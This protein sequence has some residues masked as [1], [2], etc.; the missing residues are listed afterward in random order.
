METFNSFI[1]FKE[2]QSRLKGKYIIKASEEKMNEMEEYYKDN[3]HKTNHKEDGTPKHDKCHGP[4]M[5]KVIKGDILNGLINSLNNI[6]KT[7]NAKIILQKL[8]YKTFISD[9][10]KGNYLK[11]MAMKLSQYLVYENDKDKKGEND[12]DKEQKDLKKI[13]INKVCNIIPLLNILT[14]WDYISFYLYE[15]GLDEIVPN[16]DENIKNAFIRADTLLNNKESAL[17]KEDENYR[18]LYILHLFNFKYFYGT[19]KKRKPCKN[20]KKIVK[21]KKKFLIKKY[22]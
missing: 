11:F 2:I 12:I 4:I 19:I 13:V 1:G 21:N 18:L 8:N 3:I 7:K 15:K 6:L 9:I 17:N 10:S 14:L 22:N 16:V 5:N 20:R